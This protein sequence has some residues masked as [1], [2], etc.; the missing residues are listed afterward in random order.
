MAETFIAH[1]LMSDQELA[2]GIGNHTKFA[3]FFDHYTDSFGGNDVKEYTAQ[4]KLPMAEQ[5][6][7]AYPNCQ[8][9]TDTQSIISRN[10][11]NVLYVPFMFCDVALNSINEQFHIDWS[12]TRPKT[13][14]HMGAGP[15]P[16]RI[17]TAFWLAKNYPLDQLIYSNMDTRLDMV[18][19]IIRASDYASPKHLAV[20]K[21]LDP[22]WYDFDHIKQKF[23]S[24]RQGVMLPPFD[25]LIPRRQNLY[26]GV[27]P[28]IKN[29]SYVSIQTDS[30]N[31]TP[32]SRHTDKLFQSMLGGN[33]TLHVGN[34]MATEYIQHMNLETF[35]HVFD[36]SHLAS[37]DPYRLTIEG[38]ENNKHLIADHQKI[39]QIWFENVPKLKH[40]HEMVKNG[41]H[42]RDF[43]SKEFALVKKSLSLST[44]GGTIPYK[45]KNL[46]KQMGWYQLLTHDV[47]KK[48]S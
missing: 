41:Q 21:I 34:Y 13:V 9:I 2:Q 47:D 16:C 23:M 44:S 10:Q 15:R 5:L 20:K 35:D 12:V 30:N 18:S 33:I 1:P 7:L 45:L 46:Y 22:K 17:L 31:Y 40:N 48:F 14:N 3:L 36:H 24:D 37:K 6:M 32:H 28:Y 42:W 26:F 25:V 27:V 43:F 19:W 29:Q 38:L 8:F 11:D 39:E 4:K